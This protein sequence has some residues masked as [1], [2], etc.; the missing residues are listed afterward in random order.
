M[1]TLGRRFRAAGLRLFEAAAAH[2]N[3]NLLRLLH[4]APPGAALVDLGC[5]DGEW[6]VRFG[7]AA[8]AASVHGVEIVEERAAAARERGIDVVRADL[9]AP[10]PYADASFDVVCSN[11]VIEHLA[12]TDTFVREVFRILKPGGY[13]VTS[14]ENL[15]SWHNVAA[16]ALGWQ[17]FSLTNVSHSGLGLGNPLALHR[18]ETAALKSWEHVRVFAFRG[19]RELFARHGFE[20]EAVAAAGYYPLPTRIAAR[21]PR[22]AA[23]LTL[24]ARRPRAAA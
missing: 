11:Q 5:D 10:L 14:T 19:L 4:G 9:N 16:L 3:E 8:G 6:T 15:A 23:F 13:A 20:V 22:H 7:D 18:D 17:P 24:K 2:N 21:D 1:T 12:D